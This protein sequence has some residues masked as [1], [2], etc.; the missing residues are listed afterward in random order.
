MH[1]TPFWQVVENGMGKIH[2]NKL[3]HV[4]LEKDEV[5][6]LLRPFLVLLFRQCLYHLA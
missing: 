1:F 4:F 3:E 2:L 6:K 5:M